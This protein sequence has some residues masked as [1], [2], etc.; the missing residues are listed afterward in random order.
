M[1]TRSIPDDLLALCSPG[2]IIMIPRPGKYPRA[3]MPVT[4]NMERY[5]SA[6]G[7]DFFQ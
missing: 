7:K 4:G 6:A 2:A 1:D 3:P 5:Y